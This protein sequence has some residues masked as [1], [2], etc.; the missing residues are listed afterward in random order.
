MTFMKVVGGT[1][2]VGAVIGMAFG[3]YMFIRGDID[4]SAEGLQR[5]MDMQ[6]LKSAQD[7]VD[8][9]IYKVQH[10]LDEIDTRV[11]N[12]K[13]FVTDPIQKKLLERQLTILLQ[14]K[15]EV[16]KRIETAVK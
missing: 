11:E 5:Q 2:A 12:G 9:E 8:F 6:Q 4:A 3:A 15:A 13:G 16:I 7:D 10:K 14:R 1:T